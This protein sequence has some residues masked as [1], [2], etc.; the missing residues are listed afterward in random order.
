MSY[1]S[2]TATTSC[3][4]TA[5]HTSIDDKTDKSNPLKLL[6]AD[7]QNIRGIQQKHEYEIHVHCS[8]LALDTLLHATR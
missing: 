5:P 3:V 4:I 1:T 6:D 7:K 2:T 8:F